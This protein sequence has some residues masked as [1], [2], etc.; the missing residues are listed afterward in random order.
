MVVRTIQIKQIFQNIFI[1]KNFRQTKKLMP[2]SIPGQQV[3][4]LICL[5]V[6]TVSCLALQ[7]QNR[8]GTLTLNFPTVLA[9]MKV[10]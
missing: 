7:T 3:K 8:N 10:A 5:E 2:L 6:T 4:D 1:L 9:H